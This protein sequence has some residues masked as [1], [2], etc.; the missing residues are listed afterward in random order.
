[1]QQLWSCLQAKYEPG[2]PGAVKDA[3]PEDGSFS[4]AM[5]SCDVTSSIAESIL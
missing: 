2:A 4:A 1:M 3:K 5:K